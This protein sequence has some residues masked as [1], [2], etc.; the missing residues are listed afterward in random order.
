MTHYL[1]VA[2]LS[3]RCFPLV[4]E[5]AESREKKVTQSDFLDLYR[6]PEEKQYDLLLNLLEGRTTFEDLKK[7][8]VCTIHVPC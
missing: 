4:E 8:R 7:S 6:K 1:M 5:I 2:K 3:N